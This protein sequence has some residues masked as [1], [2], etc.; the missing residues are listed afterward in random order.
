MRAGI[1]YEIDPAEFLMIVLREQ[2]VRHGLSLSFVAR[3][4]QVVVIEA[5]VE[6]LE[7]FAF[8]VS[9]IVWEC[10]LVGGIEIRGVSSEEFGEG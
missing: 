7:R 5:V 3:T 10:I 8:V 9:R 1:G 4:E 2:F 6:N